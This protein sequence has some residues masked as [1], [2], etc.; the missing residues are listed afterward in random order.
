[1]EQHLQNI[2]CGTVVSSDHI[3]CDYDNFDYTCWAIQLHV[4]MERVQDTDKFV[5]QLVGCHSRS[6]SVD[7][8]TCSVTKF[9]FPRLDVFLCGFQHSV[10]EISNNV[11]Y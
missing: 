1:M 10:L 5:Y 3:D 6:V 7:D 9:A 2:V 8:A 11:S 4:G